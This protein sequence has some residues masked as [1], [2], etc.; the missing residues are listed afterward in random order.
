LQRSPNDGVSPEVF[1]AW[2]A[3]YAEVLDKLIIRSAGQIQPNAV[4]KTTA[5]GR[6]AYL[7]G[8]V[9]GEE[10]ESELRAC[11]L[12]YAVIENPAAVAG[13]LLRS[14]SILATFK[15]RSPGSAFL[16]PLSPFLKVPLRTV[17]RRLTPNCPFR[18]VDNHLKNRSGR[19][20]V[21]KLVST[22]ESPCT[23]ECPNCGLKGEIAPR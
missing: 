5:G 17:C 13:D 22:R 15:S 8:C 6:I 4:T 1:S 23:G 16:W 7:T 2:R 21:P 3:E 12:R 18:V 11:K 10:I 9:G 14:G 19:Q 20:T